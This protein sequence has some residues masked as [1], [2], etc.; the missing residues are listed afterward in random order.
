MTW[1]AAQNSSAKLLEVGLGLLLYQWTRGMYH[2]H[3]VI[4]VAD[5]G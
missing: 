4:A 3:A 1:G 5:S 2:A